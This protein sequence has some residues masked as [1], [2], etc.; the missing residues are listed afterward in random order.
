MTKNINE[1]MNAKVTSTE[2]KVAK[3][4]ELAKSSDLSVLQVERLICKMFSKRH[5]VMYSIVEH[6]QDISADMFYTYSGHKSIIID[7]LL[8]KIYHFNNKNLEVQISDGVLCMRRK[9]SENWEDVAFNHEYNF[10]GF[11][12]SDKHSDSGKYYKSLIVKA[13]KKSF[14]IRHHQYII[15]MYVGYDVL[16]AVGVRTAGDINLY[17]IHHKNRDKTDN[18]IENLEF[19]SVVEHIARDKATRD[20]KLRERKRLF[21]FCAAIGDFTAFRG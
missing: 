17:D 21:D 8:G 6:K 5:A 14:N 9:G 2:Q 3:C 11:N 10:D 1:V 20:E 19:L 15:G 13:S 16:D 12:V 7:G 18:R 4:S